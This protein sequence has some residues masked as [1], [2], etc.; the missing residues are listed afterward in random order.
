MLL[1]FFKTKINMHSYYFV[2]NIFI[3][4]LIAVQCTEEDNS[5]DKLIEDI[6]H[7]TNAEAYTRIDDSLNRLLKT[8]YNFRETNAR[9]REEIKTDLKQQPLNNLQLAKDRALQCIRCTFAFAAK[10]MIEKFMTFVERMNTPK[11]KIENLIPFGYAASASAKVW[12]KAIGALISI[13]VKPDQWL[14]QMLILTNTLPEVTRKS[15]PGMTVGKNA[16]EQFPGITRNEDVENPQKAVNEGVFRRIRSVLVVLKSY[17]HENEKYCP[18]TNMKVWD[19]KMPEDYSTNY[20]ENV[21]RALNFECPRSELAQKDMDEL[22]K[23]YEYVENFDKLLFRNQMKHTFSYDKHERYDPDRWLVT[24]ASLKKVL[25]DGAIPNSEMEDIENKLN[26]NVRPISNHNWVL[27]YS[28]KYFETVQEMSEVVLRT[29]LQLLNRS[30]VLCKKHWESIEIVIGDR[31]LPFDFK[32]EC[33]GV[34]DPIEMIMKKF[35]LDKNEFLQTL[36]KQLR[37]IFTS[38]TEYNLIIKY[39]NDGSNPVEVKTKSDKT[40]SNSSTLEITK[41][42]M[43]EFKKYSEDLPDVY[44]EEFVLFTK[45]FYKPTRSKTTANYIN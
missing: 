26:V 18:L 12:R 6:F 41:S 36:D 3:C 33:T 22:C 30:F 28:S 37:E 13:D 20:D 5:K 38:D 29:T 17:L 43:E 35:N 9:L 1:F 44:T 42:Y 21:F 34:Q 11:K 31:K 32:N 27:Q 39:I 4:I 16:F 45:T 15:Y 23:H 8:D 25:V 14:W 7:F 2:V 10:H 19:L 40:S 24:Y